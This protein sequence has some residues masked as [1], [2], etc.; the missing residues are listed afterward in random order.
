MQHFDELTER[1]PRY[2]ASLVSLSKLLEKSNPTAFFG[3][4]GI[5]V[6]AINTVPGSSDA[7]DLGAKMTFICDEGALDAVIDVRAYPALE[8]IMSDNDSSRRKALINLWF[9][10]TLELARSE[11][12]RSLHIADI[13]PWKT[14]SCDKSLPDDTS[15]TLQFQIETRSIHLSITYISES[16]LD[17]VSEICNRRARP[18]IDNAP[19]IIDFR[20]PGR[21][22]LASRTYSI[23]QLGTLKAQDVLIGWNTLYSAPNTFSRAEIAWGA[24]AGTMLR[25]TTQIQGKN[26]TLIE[27]PNMTEDPT[28][29]PTFGGS[30]PTHAVPQSNATDQFAELALEDL[31]VP[32]HLE[33]GTLDLS[34]RTLASLKS[35]Y[36]LEL[37]IAI[38][39]AQV[40]LV[41]HGQT[42]GSGRL[43]AIGQNLGLQISKI[44]APYSPANAS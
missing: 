17:K 23:R 30:F 5:T 4:S 40:R 31:D 41:I 39:D 37:P 8:S 36:L 6:F 3:L 16:L 13:K 12:F 43:V 11:G 18:D 34:I 21:I 10:P 44:L 20:L 42:I 22:T 35:G 24:R 25:A 2:N 1:I 38:E 15:L 9:N 27:D 14:R 19:P 28:E 32:V 33:V 29:E 26:L 7:I